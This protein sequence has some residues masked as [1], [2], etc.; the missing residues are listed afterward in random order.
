MVTF[1]QAAAVDVASLHRLIESAYRGDTAK[2]GWTHEADLLGGQRTDPP[3]LRSMLADPAQTLLVA[4]DDGRLVGCVLVEAREGYGYI[5]LVTVDPQRQA[6][7]LGRQILAKAEQHIGDILRMDRARMTV[8]VQR[9][10]LIAWYERRGYADT[11]E[12]APFP[13][14]DPRFGDPAHDNL[15]FVVLEKRITRVARD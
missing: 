14:G 7:G 2:A 13:Y 10:E 11:G 4:E 3:M 8:I 6:A 15:A 9:T 1:R 5:G 12:R